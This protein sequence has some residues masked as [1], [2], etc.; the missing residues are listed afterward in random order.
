MEQTHNEM[1]GKS[2]L[3]GNT[4][5]F[6]FEQ[7]YYTVCSRITVSKKMLFSNSIVSQKSTYIHFFS[8]ITLYVIHFTFMNCWKEGLSIID[9][10]VSAGQVIFQ[11]IME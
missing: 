7:S 8:K 5:K 6:L 4:N 11:T 2:A 1:T 10:L 3:E 9:E